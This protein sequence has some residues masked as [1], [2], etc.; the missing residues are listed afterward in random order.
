M[1]D[2][3]P[4]LVDECRSL[5]DR[6]APVL[7]GLAS[8]ERLLI[9]LWLAGTAS[10]VRDL[11]KVTGLRQSMVSYHLRALR[12]AGL[13]T[14]TAVGRTNE[15]RLADPELDELARLLGNFCPPRQDSPPT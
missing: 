11:E 2:V 8:T 14:S 7:R 13:V 9:V 6:W 12:D 5:A 10:T 15:Y 1:A 3:T 4:Q